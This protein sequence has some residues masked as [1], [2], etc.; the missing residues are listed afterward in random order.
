VHSSPTPLHAPL[1]SVHGKQNDQHIPFL[2]TPRLH[3]YG[4]GKRQLKNIYS[5]GGKP[6]KK[7]I[8]QTG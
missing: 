6:E 8:V 1:Q 3:H 5:C 2:K 4:H 7:G